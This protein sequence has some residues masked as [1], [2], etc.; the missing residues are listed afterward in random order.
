MPGLKFKTIARI[1][2]ILITLVLSTR[3][4]SQQHQ[5]SIEAGIRFN[6]PARLFNSELST[7]DE[8]K[9]GFGFELHPKWGLATNKTLGVAL[10]FNLIAED[11]AT[12]DIGSF[13]IVSFLPTFKHQLLDSKFSPFYSVGLGG[14]SVLTSRTNISPGFAISVGTTLFRKGSISF[15]YNHLLGKIEVN[16]LVLRGFDRWNFYGIKLTYDIGIK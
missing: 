13:E 8:Q 1:A 10:G 7:F 11:A 16:E 5:L 12:D 14:Y 6:L 15:D 9:M 4:T 2:P 3:V